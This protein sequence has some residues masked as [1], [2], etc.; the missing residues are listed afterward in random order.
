SSFFTSVVVWLMLKWEERADDDRNLKWLIL[1]AYLLGL[2]TGVHLLNLLTIPALAFIY[3]FRKYEATWQGILATLGISIAILAFLQ[4]G[5]LQY[6]I[7]LAQQFELFFTGAIDRAGVDKGGLGY[8]MGTGSMVLGGCISLCSV[9]L[10]I[11]SHY[12]KNALISTITLCYV[13][14]MLG[15]SSYLLIFVRSGANPPLD[16]NN[17]ENVMTF[18]SYMRRE[19]YGDRPLFYGPRYNISPKHDAEGYPV[20]KDDYMRYTI[21]EG[22][23]KYVMDE[24]QQDYDFNSSDMSFFPRMYSVEPLHYNQYYS[25][26]NYEHY[27]KDKGTTD[28]PKDDKPTVLED[29]YFFLDY[30]FRQMYIRYFMWNFVGRKSDVQDAGWEFWTGDRANKANNWY[31]GLPLLLGLLG[32]I[33]Q[34]T[35]HR[36]SALV[37][38]TLFFF[39][40]IA[41]ILYLN[42]TPMQPRE[43]DYAYAGSFQTFAIWVGLGALF[44]T[45][46]FYKYLKN[47]ELAAGFAMLVPFIMCVENW[48]DHTRKGRWVDIDYA[49]NLLNSCEK[50]AILLTGGDNDTFSLWYLQE[51]EK[52]REDVRVV[53]L[54]LL[55]SDWCIDQL[56][57]KENQSPA[58][59]ID[60]AKNDYAGEKFAFYPYPQNAL[61]QLP[62]N[63]EKVIENGVISRE[64]ADLLADTLT[65]RIKGK[66]I[67]YRKDSALVN[68]VR[69]VAKENWKRPVYFAN[70]MGTGSYAN[71]QDYLQ[72]EGMAYRLV[73]IQKSEKTANDIV[74]GHIA[75]EKMY[76][77]L[78]QV[79]R[80]R[81]L[82]D[83][84]VNH[85]EHIRTS[86]I[87][88]YRKAFYRL[89]NS[90]AEQFE[91]WTKTTIKEDSVNGQLVKTEI[92]PVAGHEK[93]AAVAV[94]KIQKLMQHARK[95]MPYEV[96]PIDLSQL[97]L[98][99]DLYWRVNLRQ[100]A[101]KEYEAVAILAQKK[102]LYYA[103]IIEAYPQAMEMFQNELQ[104]A[105]RGLSSSIEY[106]VATQQ[107]AKAQSIAKFIKTQLNSNKG[108]ELIEKRNAD[109]KPIN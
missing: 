37:V 19:Q 48:D 39:T 1:I 103:E 4:Y 96:I 31:F 36:K 3:Y 44:L 10:L 13:V 59:Q 21:W 62:I 24:M 85:D 47:K 57:R 28:N 64:N 52:V 45:E 30:Q 82:D 65:W 33:W 92:P 16:M 55:I 22:Q 66:N 49:Y 35:H 81:G 79:F 34:F 23:K 101:D 9:A 29:A 97:M 84:R 106:Y 104:V 20:F 77:N 12:R 88:A 17:P 107:I 54:E 11:F 61:V 94:E 56:K 108:F 18:L 8:P 98:N 25:S 38:G 70:T 7:S 27:V 43:R 90:Y 105:Y 76:H 5:V 46:I 91:K 87:S 2:S 73:P 51:V 71:L 58:F 95:V 26:Y 74:L 109:A 42:Q 60:M 100:E 50:N 67:I 99:A 93:E 102:M 68:L 40:G 14:I 78:M 83:G 86:I 80:F 72:L 41:I 75:Q 89:G 63:K 32:F 6:T 15:F 69:N 53:N